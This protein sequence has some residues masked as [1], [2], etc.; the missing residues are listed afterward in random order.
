MFG[1]CPALLP[2]KWETGKK[3]LPHLNW[4]NRKISHFGNNTT[5]TTDLVIDVK[6]QADIQIEWDTINHQLHESPITPDN[7]FIG[8]FFIASPKAEPSKKHLGSR[9]CLSCCLA[10]PYPIHISRSRNSPGILLARDRKICPCPT[11][12]PDQK[13]PRARVFHFPKNQKLLPTLSIM[14]QSNPHDG[15]TRIFLLGIIQEKLRISYVPCW[16]KGRSPTN[17][18]H[19]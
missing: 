12:W 17:P 18:M 15:P 6:T 13:Y 16:H 7:L 8:Q 2:W 10:I 14:A 1:K 19:F 11:L 4:L 3:P 9:T 5:S